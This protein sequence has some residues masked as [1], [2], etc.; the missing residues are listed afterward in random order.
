[1][2]RDYPVCVCLSLPLIHFKVTNIVCM[3]TLVGES[4]L[5]AAKDSIGH[6]AGSTDSNSAFNG[7]ISQGSITANHPQTCWLA[8]SLL[9]SGFCCFGASVFAV[10]G[11]EGLV[12]LLG[13]PPQPGPL[14]PS[15]LKRSTASTC[16]R[17]PKPGPELVP[18]VRRRR[19]AQ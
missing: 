15:S 3:S 4:V 11:L 12:I 7:L 16:R 14:D 10:R 9:G 19:A 17:S 5:T 18:G 13:P 2:S 1:M 8:G 6:P